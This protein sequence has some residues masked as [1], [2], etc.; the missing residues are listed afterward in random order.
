MIQKYKK[1]TVEEKKMKIHFIGIGGIGISALVQYYLAMGHRVSG[2]DF[3]PSEITEFLKRKG[4]KI[5]IGNSA[6]HITKDLDLVIFSPAVQSDNPEF[7]R[8]HY[9]GIKTI[10]YPQAL[11][12]LTKKYKT[13]AVAGAHGKSTTTAMTALVLIAAGLDPTVIIGT[14]LKEFK[15]SNFRLGKSDILIIEA[16]EYE[17]SFLNYSPQIIILTN[18]DKEHLDY[19]KNFNN[20]LKS[21]FKFIMKLPTDG[22]LIINKDDPGIRKLSLFSKKLKFKIKSYSLKQKDSQKIKKILKVP[23]THNISNALAVLAMARELGIPDKIIFRALSHFRGTWRRFEIKERMINKKRITVISDY[24]HHPTELAATFQA[25][26]ERYKNQKIWCLFQPH[27][28]QRTFFLFDDF[29]RVFRRNDIDMIIITDIYKVMGREMEEIEKKVSAQ[30]LVKKIK[31][32]NVLYLPLDQAKD[33]LKTHLKSV[34]V[35]LIIGAGD[36]YKLA[37]SLK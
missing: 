6:R 29:T 25:A 24:A 28:H 14:K 21:F 4:A 22:I 35:L 15:N 8:A 23:G 36:I 37:N 31:R 18:I 5:L 30:Q 13:I 3:V 27:Q 19:F 32:K 9:F 33:Y 12:E 20:V 2:S 10:S 11:G 1:Q 16:C 26:R 7:K 34:D 17:D